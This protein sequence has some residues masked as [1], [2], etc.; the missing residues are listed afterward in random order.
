MGWRCAHDR[1]VVS[2]AL[3]SDIERRRVPGRA[4]RGR[5]KKP[6]TIPPKDP[7]ALVAHCA[8]L[9]VAADPRGLLLA[10]PPTAQTPLRAMLNAAA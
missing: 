9:S 5:E 8:L 4:R 3:K 6:A 1:D 10:G 7:I 2:D